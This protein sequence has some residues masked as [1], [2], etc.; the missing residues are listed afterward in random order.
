M[1]T[2]ASSFDDLKE[3]FYNF[4]RDKDGFL[5][6]DEFRHIIT[7]L[8]DPMPA[9]EIEAFITEADPQ[10]TGFVDYNALATMMWNASAEFTG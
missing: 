8:G 3:A 10:G 5:S 9:Q 1:A 4:D 7:N 6:I 2:A